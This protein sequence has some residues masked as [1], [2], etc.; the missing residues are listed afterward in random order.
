VPDDLRPV[1]LGYRDILYSK[2]KY[3]AFFGTA[4]GRTLRINKS[5]YFKA[6]LYSSMLPIV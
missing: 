6:E 2:D 5:L 1:I 4:Y 3:H